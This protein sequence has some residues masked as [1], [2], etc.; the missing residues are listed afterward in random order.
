MLTQ[1]VWSKGEGEPHVAHDDSSS[2]HGAE[3]EASAETEG[4]AEEAEISH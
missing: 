3:N 2:V 1:E 4:D